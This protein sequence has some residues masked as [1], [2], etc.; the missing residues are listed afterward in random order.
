MLHTPFPHTLTHQPLS[1]SAH[2]FMQI[3]TD[4]RAPGPHFPHT[5]LHSLPRSPSDRTSSK[6]DFVFYTNRICRIVVE[7]GLG[8]LPFKEKVVVTPAGVGE[9]VRGGVGEWKQEAAFLQ[10]SR[11]WSHPQVWGRVWGWAWGKV[12]GRVRG[13]GSFSARRR[14]WSPPQVWGRVWRGRVDGYGCTTEC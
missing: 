3:A 11:W 8:Q 7:A 5:L 2:G 9:R 1:K 12:Q 13:W 6:N 14:W 4:Q 10:R